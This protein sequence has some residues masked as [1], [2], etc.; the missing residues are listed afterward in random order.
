MFQLERP[1]V[2]TG[3]DTLSVTSMSSIASPALD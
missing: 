2:S 3:G 1:W